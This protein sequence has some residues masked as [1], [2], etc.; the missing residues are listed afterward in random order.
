MQFSNYNQMFNN[1]A[2]VQHTNTARLSSN[3]FK[4]LFP[5]LSESKAESNHESEV[6]A[7]P[8]VAIM[9]AKMQRMLEAMKA[10]QSTAAGAQDSRYSLFNTA[11]NMAP[12]FNFGAALDCKDKSTDKQPVI[13]A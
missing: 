8:A 12:K 5:L 7:D 2:T 11:S 6:K 3:H 9:R 13:S 4:P 1:Q 10:E